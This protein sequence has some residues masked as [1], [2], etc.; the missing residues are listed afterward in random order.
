MRHYTEIEVSLGGPDVAGTQSLAT[1]SQIDTRPPVGTRIM[2]Y[3]KKVVLCTKFLVAD[4][5]P[6]Y[7]LCQP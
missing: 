1:I 4:S 2:R 7:T 6:P 3:K 5:P